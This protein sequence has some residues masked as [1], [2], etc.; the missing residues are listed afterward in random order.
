M[1]LQLH[2]AQVCL[3]STV[4]YRGSEWNSLILSRLKLDMLV[5]APLLAL[6]GNRLSKRVI[7][8]PL[9]SILVLH[10]CTRLTVLTAQGDQMSSSGWMSDSQQIAEDESDLLYITI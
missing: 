7:L 10:D 1:L 5:L 3:Y 4:H 8:P 6:E 2:L 9:T